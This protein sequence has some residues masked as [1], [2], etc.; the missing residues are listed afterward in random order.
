MFNIFFAHTIVA[1]NPHLCLLGGIVFVLYENHVHW[2]FS[3]AT[4]TAPADFTRHFLRKILH[5]CR[6]IGSS[7]QDL[8]FIAIT[9]PLLLKVGET[10]WIFRISGIELCSDGVLDRHVSFLICYVDSHARRQPIREDNREWKAEL[11]WNGNTIRAVWNLVCDWA[12]LL[13][14]RVWCEINLRSATFSVSYHSVVFFLKKSFLE[15]QEFKLELARCERLLLIYVDDA[16]HSATGL[17]WLSL[18]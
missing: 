12:N 9:G 8:L 6:N 4:T 16:L 3:P 13:W 15:S 2:E 1:N 14:A 7:H 11:T 18:V 5:W 10:F 17:E